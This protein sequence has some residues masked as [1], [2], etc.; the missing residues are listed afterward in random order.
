MPGRTRGVVVDAADAT[1]NTWYAAGVGGGLK[2]ADF[3]YGLQSN[4]YA[5][6]ESITVN[7]D[8]I[9]YVKQKNLELGFVGTVLRTGLA[10]QEQ[11]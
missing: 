6:L 3:I 5:E 4:E 7:E 1:G 11:H 9:I 2:P 10:E 8:N